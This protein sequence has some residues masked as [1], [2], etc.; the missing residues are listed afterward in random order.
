MT[1]G[2]HRI[3]WSDTHLGVGVEIA[4]PQYSQ[5]ARVLVRAAQRAE[6]LGYDSLWAVER[7]L[8][9]LAPRSPY[10]GTPDGSM[11]AFLK[12]AFTP[13][14]TLAYVAA[15]TRN[16]AIGTSILS[17]PLHNPVMLARQLATLDVLSG[18]RLR[19]GLG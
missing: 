3:V 4:A 8:Y 7:L 17:M 9:P 2:V 13:V 15:H 18:G 10:P 16:I 19:V 11:P 14:E 6:E 5:R 1:F 12:R